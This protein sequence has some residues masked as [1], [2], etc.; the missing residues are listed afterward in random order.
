MDVWEPVLSCRLWGQQCYLA[1]VEV[2]W[3]SLALGTQELCFY[4]PAACTCV[5]LIAVLANVAEY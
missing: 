1:A 4:C 5:D 2:G 3:S